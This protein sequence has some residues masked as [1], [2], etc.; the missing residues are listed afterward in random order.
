MLVELAAA[1]NAEPFGS[2]MQRS[3]H[4]FSDEATGLGPI[5]NAK[6]KNGLAYVVWNKTKFVVL[7]SS[8]PW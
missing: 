7:D 1:Q 8:P 2:A 3:Q 6:V 4:I 5:A